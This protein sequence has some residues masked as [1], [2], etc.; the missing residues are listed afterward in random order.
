MWVI[1]F[2]TGP[3]KGKQ[4]VLKMGRNVIGRSPQNDISVPSPS[5]SKEHFILEVY[6]DKVILSDANSRNGTFINDLQI[7]NQKLGLGDKI[8]VGEIL[9]DVVPK[10]ISPGRI[11][12]KPK[13]NARPSGPAYDGNLA[14]DQSAQAEEVVTPPVSLVSVEYG[15]NFISYLQKYMDEVA[16]PGVYKLLEWTDFKSLL[17]LFVAG[18][19][20]LV[21]IMSSVPLVRILKESVQQES[22]NRARTIA[23]N[24]ALMNRSALSQGIYSSVNVDMAI[25][26]PGVTEAY[27]IS[28]INGDIIAPAKLAGKYVEEP[29]VNRAR[30][31]VSEVIEQI[32]DSTIGA[33]VP[34]RQFNSMTNTESVAAHAVVIYDMGSL[35]VDDSRTL[36]LIVQVLVI[37]LIFGSI[38]YFLLYKIILRPIDDL[39]SQLDA[40]LRQGNNQVTTIYKFPEIEKL[41]SNINSAVN[42][43]S[44]TYAASKE[45]NFESDRSNEILGLLRLV[46]YASIAVHAI[47][48]NI[49]QQNENFTS[50]ISQ[51]QNWQ[52]MALNMINDQSLKLNLQDLTEKAIQSP[53]QIASDELPISDTNYEITAQAVMGSQNVAYVV[54][55]FIPRSSP[56]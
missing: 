38:L 31:E 33:L 1:R 17:A 25:R 56:E 27:I 9:M 36:S 16:L 19:V 52:G 39:N 20:V 11:S 30:K 21:T 14:Y 10:T 5:M 13:N 55:A 32:N 42:R 22:Q 50:Q 6:N 4:K 7:K 23:R 54:I 53:N 12:Q 40:A 46:G 47:D 34:I 2:Y 45:V 43:S 37:S 8:R 35:A 51:G 18:F 28:N 48:R 44:N 26:E 24:L 41:A 15:K 29:F 49:L 3:L